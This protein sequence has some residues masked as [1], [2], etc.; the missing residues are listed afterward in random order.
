MVQLVHIAGQRTKAFLH[1]FRGIQISVKYGKVFMYALMDLTLKQDVQALDWWVPISTN[2]ASMHFCLLYRSIQLG[3]P[4]FRQRRA[5]SL[6]GCL[7]DLGENLCRYIRRCGLA[8]EVGWDGER[9]GRWPERG[10]SEPEVT[11]MP[12]TRCA[13]A[14]NHNFWPPLIRAS[15]VLWLTKAPSHTTTLF[16]P[17]SLARSGRTSLKARFVL[18]SSSMRR[19][20]SN[21]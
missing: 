13:S 9:H 18:Q 21:C 7:R 20:Y 16:L 14:P 17:P 6:A 11:M 8:R 12:M 5:Q 10:I 2:P 15:L 1:G 4:R 19:R 3:D